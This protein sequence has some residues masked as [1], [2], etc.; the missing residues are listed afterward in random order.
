MFDKLKSFA[1]NSAI[2]MLGTLLSRAT[3]LIS[4]PV[5]TRYLAPGE[6]G[7]LSVVSSVMGIL[8]LAYNMGIGGSTTRYYYDLNSDQERKSYFSSLLFFLLAAAFLLSFLLMTFGEVLLAPLLKREIPF[9]PYL[10]VAVW[11]L[12][13]QPIGGLT[14]SLM[15]VREQAARFITLQTVRSISVLTLSILLVVLAGMGALG[16]ILASFL[17]SAL[18]TVY[19]LYYLWPYLGLTFR[20]AP[21]RESLAFG[22]PTVPQKFGGWVLRGSDRLFLL[23]FAS[24][25]AAGIYSISYSLGLLLSLLGRSIENAWTPFFYAVARD[26]SEKEAQRIF[27]YAATYYTLFIVS[28]GL[29]LA[30]F[31]RELFHILAP[32][33]Y[34]AGLSIVPWIILG[35]IF[36]ALYDIPSRGIYLMKKTQWLPVIVL[37]AAAVNTGFNF[38]LIP[39]WG[40]MGAAWATLIGYS[41]MIV[42]TFYLA[43]RLYY[44]PYDYPRLAKIFVAAIAVYL[45]STWLSPDTLIPALLI[46]VTAL[47]SYPIVLWLLGFFETA[48]LSRMRDVVETLAHYVRGKR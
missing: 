20:W 3:E 12:F 40:M 9:H 28:L 17:V 44:V 15:R 14:A 46:K 32:A 26:E 8:G 43:Q 39:A 42:L 36:E 47:V 30:I 35:S 1:K 34:L 27:S 10:T 22:L 38:A 18:T 11:T 33:K 21:V 31:A 41:V 29:A 25:S 37:T 23:H 7:I 2:Y 13:F 4:M 48:E 24:V 5:F 16:P 45:I 19:L 6:Y